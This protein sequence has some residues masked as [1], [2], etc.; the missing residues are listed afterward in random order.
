MK[1]FSNANRVPNGNMN[2]LDEFASTMLQKAPMTTPITK[3]HQE[4]DGYYDMNDVRSAKNDTPYA[5]N[6][7]GAPFL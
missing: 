6:G 4:F 1:P 5:T 3:N 2:A 7:S